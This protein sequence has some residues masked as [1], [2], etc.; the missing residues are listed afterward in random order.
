[1]VLFLL[2]IIE[3]IIR[4][5]SISSFGFRIPTNRIVLII[6]TAL[7]ASSLIG[8]TVRYFM[9]G[10]G[11]LIFGISSISRLISRLVL[12]PLVE[13]IYFRGLIQTHLEAGLGVVLSWMLTGLLFGFAH[14]WTHFLI[15]G[16][17]LTIPSLTQLIFTTFS[18]MLLGIIFAKTRSLLPPFLLHTIHNNVLASMT[19]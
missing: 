4:R 9:L 12:G 2:F 16:R 6:F 18:G 8:G 19:W 3:K 1:M 11:F 14:Y 5:R 15:V 13:E 10:S 7:V 17:T